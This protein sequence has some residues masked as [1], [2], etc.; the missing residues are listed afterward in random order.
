MRDTT[1]AP[2]KISR[3]I[4]ARTETLSAI[5]CNKSFLAMKVE[6]RTYPSPIKR[7]FWCRSKFDVGEMLALAC[8]KGKGNKVLCQTCAEKLIESAKIEPNPAEESVS[9]A[10]PETPRKE[11][12]V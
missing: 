12:R 4:P 8:L 7:C 6:F 3:R 10:D 2:M 1:S 5:W 9:P 11:A